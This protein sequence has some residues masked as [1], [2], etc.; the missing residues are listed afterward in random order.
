MA[1]ASTTVT[2]P[3]ANEGNRDDK[4]RKIVFEWTADDADGSVDSK[5][6]DG[7]VHGFI[8]RVVT[9]PGSTAPTDDYDITLSDSDGADVLGGEGADRDTAN[10][11][12]IIPKL[13]NAYGP[14]RV[15]SVLTLAVSNNSVNSAT[16]KV[17]VYLDRE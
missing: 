4:T 12:Q 14:C 7:S 17:I 13:G 16:G 15:D 1:N 10:S 6:T 3:D 5:A 11:E 8:T 9:D 2:M